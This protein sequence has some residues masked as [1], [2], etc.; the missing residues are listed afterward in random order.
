MGTIYFFA[1]DVNVPS[2]GILA[3]YR[4]VD[5]LAR[6]G[7]A[8]RVLHRR[9]G[10]RCTW[11]QNST[12]VAAADETELSTRDV[13]VLS[14]LQGHQ[15]LTAAPGVP[16]V[17]LNNHQYWTFAHGSADYRHPD[18]QVAVAVSQDGKEYLQCAFPGLQVERVHYGIDAGPFKPLARDRRRI[19]IYR[20]SKNLFATGQIEHL[21]R[22]GNRESEWQLRPLPDLGH[23][24]VISEIN[25]AAIFLAT[26][27]YEGFQ[28]MAAEA[29]LGGC[30]VVGFPAGGGKEFFNPEYSCPVEQGNIAGFVRAIEAATRLFDSDPSTVTKMTSQA[31]AF[32][33]DL[34]S[35]DLEAADVLRIFPPILDKLAGVSPG[36][37]VTLNLPQPT[38]WYRAARM[39]RNLGREILSK[40]G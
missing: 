18:V 38:R 9:R 19:L 6:H 23:A 14:E 21:W 32:V 7:V 40:G 10:F 27:E 39:A 15:I 34:C 31:A 4:F 13:L 2:G 25:T 12:P 33:K 20:A 1:E 24:E 29:M 5:I 26:S 17:I 28:I 22:N 3:V 37:G 36:R 30:L 35:P 16:K 11:F 8:A